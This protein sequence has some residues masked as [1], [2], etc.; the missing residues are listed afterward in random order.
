MIL[1]FSLYIRGTIL[2]YNQ[3]SASVVE[4]FPVLFSFVE[5]IFIRSWILL[6]PTSLRI[7]LVRNLHQW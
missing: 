7:T 6:Y 5:S 3:K 4:V 1:L 2:C